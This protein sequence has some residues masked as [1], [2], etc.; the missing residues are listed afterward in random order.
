MIQIRQGVFETNSSST[1]AI[2][3]MAYDKDKCNIPNTVTF[4]TDQDFGWEF[5][6]YTDYIS[7]A[8][9]I[10][11]TLCSRYCYLKDEK[12]LL[13]CKHRLT[14][15]LQDA[16]VENVLFAENSYED[17]PW[18]DEP[19]LG[20]DGYVDHYSDLN[21]MVDEMMNDPEMLLSYLF[22]DRSTVATG[23]DNSEHDPEFID[24]AKW[25]IWKGN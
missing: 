20:L 16:G 17:T 6:K 4:S 23:N 24:N 10:W 8:A 14:K 12:R 21:D 19:Y 11:T 25:M 22:D 7:K 5:E 3:I 18:G 15:I 13:D 9:Y 2:S 1:H